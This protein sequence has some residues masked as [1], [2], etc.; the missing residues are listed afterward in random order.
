MN[1]NAGSG[2]RRVEKAFNMLSGYCANMRYAGWDNFDG[3]NSTVFKGSFLYRSAVLRLVWTQ[4]F[5]KSPVNFRKITGVP[6]GYNP[7]GLALFISGLT[8]QK[9]YEEAEKLIGQLRGMC[10][11]G[12][13]GSSWGYNFDWQSRT[14]LT[15]VGTPNLVTTVF[16][17]NALL[18]YCNASGK[19][20]YLDLVLDGC[21]FFL[22]NLV[23]YEDRE[24]LC[25]G[26]MPGADARVHN[27]N[28]LG[29]TVL[30]RVYRL[31][32]D[33]RYLEKSRKSMTYAVRALRPDFSWPY[34]EKSFQQFV[35]NF[36]TG[37][38]L[39]SL[40][41][42]MEYTG[43]FAWEV[44]FRKAARYF[45]D[46]FWLEDGCPKYYHDSLYPIDIHCSAQGI[47]TFLKLAGYEEQSLPMA[48][49]IAEWAID[50]MQDGEEGFF[51]Y[52]K[53][54]WY[55]NRIPYIRW[56]QAW[57]YYGL[58]LLLRSLETTECIRGKNAVFS[59]YAPVSQD[60]SS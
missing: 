26:Y 39:V 45:M 12:Y 21:R 2:I 9:R 29:A 16:V 13:S 20:E 18:D 27:V 37:F 57:M 49:K 41:D 30:A 34:G 52:Q 43:D 40:R 11:H 59:P 32:G 35:D 8:C 23:Q 19:D 4:F 60:V 33:A 36:H 48:V 24:T 55:A 54:R 3:L 50:N 42:W 56:S 17:L 53:T 44:P 10:C 47:V 1:G 15:P 6:Y 5:K 14:F 58:S 25:F 31:T 38:N 7:K 46:T 28:M 51:Y 22:E